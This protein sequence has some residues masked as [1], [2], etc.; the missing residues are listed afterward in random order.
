MERKRETV[1]L[2]DELAA[3]EANVRKATELASRFAVSC[4]RWV[5]AAPEVEATEELAE[6]RALLDE[7]SA[8]VDNCWKASSRFA[9]CYGR[10]LEAGELTAPEV[11]AIEEARCQA[12]LNALTA[13]ATVLSALR[14]E[15]RRTARCNHGAGGGG[16][17]AGDGREPQQD[18]HRRPAASRRLISMMCS[19]TLASSPA[20]RM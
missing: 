18:H 10:L 3:I 15:A 20:C 12:V 16:G 9:A 11:E 5:Q 1:V 7:F 2:L 17:L 6:T 4:E 19:G 14:P 13:T 8:H